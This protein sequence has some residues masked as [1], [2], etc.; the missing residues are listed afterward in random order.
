MPFP[1]ITV[2]PDGDNQTRTSQ[3]DGETF[4][5]ASG[6]ATT[7]DGD[8]VVVFANDGVTFRNDGTANTTG[9]TTTVVIEGDRGTVDNGRNAEISAEQTAIDIL[10]EDALIDNDGLIVGGFNGVNFVNGGLSSGLLRNDGTISSDSRA[11]NI[12]GDGVRVENYGRIIGTDDQRNGTIYSDAT[13]NDYSISNRRDAVVDAGL[14]NDGAGIA[15]QLGSLVDGS[16]DNTG[17]IRG[18]GQAEA[19]SGLAGDGIRLFSGV[20]GPSTFEGNIT[21]DG[22]ILSDSE[23]GPVAGLR[24]ANGVNFDGTITNG[25]RG[26]I[27]GANN[28]LYFGTGEHD[29]VVVNHGLISS[30]SRAVNIDGSGVELNNFGDIIGTG[31]QR[32]GTV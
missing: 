5:L 27:S 13:A 18:R 30:D 1:F 22:R 7:V 15:L 8:P 10:G 23:V 17:T 3:V 14:G 24:V 32:N 21:N 16:I 28:G 9:L 12:G 6:D 19:S 26:E 4:V 31:D 29:A 25:R 20:E 2:I 11:V